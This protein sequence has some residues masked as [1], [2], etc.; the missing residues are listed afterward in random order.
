MACANTDAGAE[1]GVTCNWLVNTV[2]N[3]ATPTELPIDRKE[4][5]PLV[6]VPRSDFR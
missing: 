3:T 4:V 6:P 5:A 2:P 1:V